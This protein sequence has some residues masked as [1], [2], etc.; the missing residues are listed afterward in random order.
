M[1]NPEKHY[2]KQIIEDSENLDGFASAHIQG[3]VSCQAELNR[4]QKIEAVLSNL[5]ELPYPGQLKSDILRILWEQ[6]AYSLWQLLFGTFLLLISPLV[7]QYL[8]LNKPG[9]ELHKN[10][11][12]LIFTIYGILISLVMVVISYRIYNEIRGKPTHTT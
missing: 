5:P 9:I 12:I 2:R 8:I 11:L 6:P 10:M 7:M 4:I 3:C 1:N